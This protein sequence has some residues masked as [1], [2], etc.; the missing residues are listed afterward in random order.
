MRF[1]L[2]FIL[3]FIALN[4]Y[5]QQIEQADKYFLYFK[6]WNFIKY[7]HPN[8]ALGRIDADS[9]FFNYLTEI[10]STK[11][12]KTLNKS[13]SKLLKQFPAS[14]NTDI[15]VNNASEVLINNLDFNWFLKNPQITN[16]NKKAYLEILE[17][18]YTQPVHHYVPKLRYES[19][20]PNERVYDFADKETIP[21]EFRLLALAKMQGAVD[22]LYPHKY[23]ME[24]SF[25]SVLKPAIT[26]MVKCKSM[27]EYELLLLK[28]V[29][30]LQDTHSFGFFKQL[31][32]RRDIFKNSFYPPF[33]YQIFED[34]I[35]VTDI[36]VPETCRISDIQKGDFITAIDRRSVEHRIGDLSSLLSASNHQALLHRLSYYAENLIWNLDNKQVDVEIVRDSIKT[37][38]SVPF[39]EIGDSDAL[40]PVNAYLAST[41]KKKS[42]SDDLTIL[43]NDIAYFKI[44]DTFRFI[45]NVA[46]E[47]VETHMDSIFAQARQ[48]KGIIFDMRGYPD[49]GGFAYTYLIKNFGSTPHL[50]AKYYELNKEKIG[51]YVHNQ[52]I[53]TYYNADINI[54]NTPYNG[55]VVIIVNS[56]TLSQSEW[57][58]M[59]LQ[60]LFPNAIRMGEQS[61]G[62][63]GDLK[64]LNLP[65]KYQ[66]NFTGNAIFYNDG[67]EAQRAGVK[68]DIPLMTPKE[69]IINKQDYMLKKA[70]EAIEE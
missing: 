47:K 3:L 45:E 54:K 10:E 66:L 17:N 19:E 23:L 50:Y 29:A 65:G 44:S 35:L 41:Q 60:H 39:I 1:K 43:N 67:S 12:K 15:E 34:G 13:L 8:L 42:S 70:I 63:D 36:I 22:Y 24:Q 30:S 32:H 33:A 7:Y 48:Q 61:A 52:D 21:L 16:R 56:E 11:D 49:W 55:K 37:S 18:R 51:T 68:I 4:S 9:L 62:A 31:K 2:L 5:G 20:V 58:T 38:K 40:K 6:T 57:N 14:H 64:I 26:S 59:N 28:L 27:L 69:Y 25:D 46:D 53:N